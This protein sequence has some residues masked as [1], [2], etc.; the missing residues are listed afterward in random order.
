MTADGSIET[1]DGRELNPEYE[2]VLMALHEGVLYRTLL[3]AY[4]YFSITQGR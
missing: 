3:V 2:H 1:V 4:G